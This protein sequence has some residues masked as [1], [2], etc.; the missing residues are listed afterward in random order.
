MIRA[1]PVAAIFVSEVRIDSLM[2]PG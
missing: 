1:F 2:S